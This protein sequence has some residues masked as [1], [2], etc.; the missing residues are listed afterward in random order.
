MNAVS[1]RVPL[2]L[3]LGAAMLLPTEGQA[4]QNATPQVVGTAA[5]VARSDALLARVADW[6]LSESNHGRAARL[7]VEAARLR[8]PDDPMV[9]EV[10]R[11]AANRYYYAD[12][13]SGAQAT[14]EEAAVHAVEYGSLLKAAHLFLDAASVAH[15]RGS[16]AQ[17][18]RLAQR[19]ERL[20]RS[21]HLTTVQV[22]QI[23]GRILR[24]PVVMVS[25]PRP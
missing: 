25:L 13:L 23:E 5:A 8:A 4:L 15:E 2:T 18:Q 20:T 17:A 22:S 16:A 12:N 1:S 10:L 14:L 11:Q 9:V 24:A 7:L 21:P 6:E 19:A 3:L